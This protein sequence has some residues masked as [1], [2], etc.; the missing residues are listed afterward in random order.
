VK[1]DIVVKNKLLDTIVGTIDKDVAQ[2]I[3]MDGKSINKKITE[4]INITSFADKSGLEIR[5]KD[6]S[7][8]EYVFIPA[9]ITQSGLNEVVYNDFYIGDN[10]FVIIMAGCG[11]SNHGDE[12]SKH[13]GL[14]RLFIGKNSKVKY[15]E[16]HYGE[17]DH[18]KCTM[19]PKTYIELG[20]G[21]KLEMITSQI[22]GIDSS[23]RIVEA[24][25]EKDSTLICNESIYTENEQTVTSLFNVDLNGE[26]S[27]VLIKSRSMVTDDSKQVFKSVI[28]GNTKC[29]GHV[30]CDAIIEGNGQV[31]SI[32]EINAYNVDANLVHE[33][34]IGRI[35]EEQLIKL[36]TL[37]KTKKEAEDI[38]VKGF[39]NEK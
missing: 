1:G 38:I 30:E 39:L 17:T 8:L 18:A 15:L 29:Y 33:A 20:V 32:P 13:D 7:K 5:V 22:K 3:R 34:T 24:K 6:N 27:S 35:A 37:G 9:I 25:L 19:N 36:M 14:H 31:K 4:N 11:I 21:S 10:S 23:N 2:N 12:D 16:K 26:N 28:N